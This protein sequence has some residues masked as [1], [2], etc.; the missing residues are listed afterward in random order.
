[1]INFYNIK[2]E[3]TREVLEMMRVFY[4]SPALATSGSDKIFEANIQNCID[5]NPYLEGFVISDGDKTIGYSMIAKSFSTEYGV[6]CVW[7]EDLY[8]IPDYRGKGIA[9]RF[10]AFLEQRFKGVL[11]RLEVAQQN[12][13]AITA[14]YKNGFS[15]MPYL[16]L[17][18]LPD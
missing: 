2:K 7:I 10:F 9:S 5:D 13:S 12:E 18:K 15:P 14:Y 1:M 16:E 11:F 17:K 8:L 6:P 4:A 3:N